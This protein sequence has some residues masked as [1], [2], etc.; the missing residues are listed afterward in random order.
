[1]GEV[2]SRGVVGQIWCQEQT[3]S[4]TSGD[5]SPVPVWLYTK[6]RSDIRDEFDYLSSRKRGCFMLAVSGQQRPKTVFFCWGRGLF[7][8][9]VNLS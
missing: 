7:N 5:L 2:H 6:E 8:V 4:Q 9:N 1:M 3:Y